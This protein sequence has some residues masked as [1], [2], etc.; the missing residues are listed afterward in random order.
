M[1]PKLG[2]CR[3]EVK[4]ISA[5]ASHPGFIL[6]LFHLLAVGQSPLGTIM[7]PNSLGKVTN[8]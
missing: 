5:R 2:Q 7:V 4:C 8:S 1:I 6:Q 3:V